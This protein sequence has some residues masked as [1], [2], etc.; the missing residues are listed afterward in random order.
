MKP[1]VGKLTTTTTKNVR[2]AQL[3]DVRMQNVFE[4]GIR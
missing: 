1:P 4:G 2:Q 3:A